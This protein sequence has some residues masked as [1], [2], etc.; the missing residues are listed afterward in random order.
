[1]HQGHCE[2]SGAN[3]LG[4]YLLLGAYGLYGDDDLLLSVLVH[5]GP[6]DLL[7]LATSSIACCR[8]LEDADGTGVRLSLVQRFCD[9]VMWRRQ[10][11][12]A[13]L[14]AVR[15]AAIKSH[16]HKLS[17]LRALAWLTSERRAANLV[18][19]AAELCSASD[20]SSC[21]ALV[22]RFLDELFGWEVQRLQRVA[23]P[24]SALE[25]ACVDSGLLAVLSIGGAAAVAAAAGTCAMSATERALD[26]LIELQ[27]ERLPE[28]GGFVSSAAR[29]SAAEFL[30]LRLQ[31][32]LP[33]EDQTFAAFVESIHSLDSTIRSWS[34]EG[35]ELSCPPATRRGIPYSHWW[36]FLG[37]HSSY[38]MCA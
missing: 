9:C 13:A 16:S 29:R 2:M 23:S 28:P 34:D 5:L 10:E 32:V 27:P 8:R 15:K 33:A 36:A 37:G 25:D 24:S 17:T 11:H 14:E 7:S 21:C 38:G 3:N 31:R 1:L 35:Y 18:S 22:G 4:P 20:R 6:P 26:E 19:V 12:L 30:R